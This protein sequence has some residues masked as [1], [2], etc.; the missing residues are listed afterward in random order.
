VKLEQLDET[1]EIAASRLGPA[2]A[3]FRKLVP[4]PVTKG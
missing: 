1:R 3:S 4:E 2:Y